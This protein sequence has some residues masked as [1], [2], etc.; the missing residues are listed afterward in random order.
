LR[1]ILEAWF[2]AN[3][4]LTAPLHAIDLSRFRWRENGWLREEWIAVYKNM[5]K[6]LFPNENPDRVVADG[7]KRPLGRAR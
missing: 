3:P 1:E 2:V 6:I 7:M 5:V 4:S